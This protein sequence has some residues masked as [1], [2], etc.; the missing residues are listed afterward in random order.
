MI[1]SR[2]RAPLPKVIHTFRMFY[3]SNK[4]N[5]VICLYSFSVT[6]MVTCSLVMPSPSVPGTRC[7]HRA[8]RSDMIDPPAVS[9]S[10]LSGS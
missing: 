5:F 7:P 2:G 10:D 1:Y 3:G 8:R 4:L 6:F 9:G